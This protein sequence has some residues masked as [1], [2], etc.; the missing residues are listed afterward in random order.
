M[1]KITGRNIFFLI[2]FLSLFV[3]SFNSHAFDAGGVEIE[4]EPYFKGGSIGWDQNEG[5]GGHKFTIGGGLNTSIRYDAFKGVVSFD[6]WVHGEKMD[7]DVGIIPEDGYTISGEAAYRIAVIDD[8]ALSPYTIFGYEKWNR[9]G[10][11]GWETLEFYMLAV[12]MEAEFNKGYAKLAV[13][14][15]LSPA[16]DIQIKSEEIKTKPGLIAE[17]GMNFD[18]FVVGLFYKHL[19]FE[20]PDA[21][22]IQSGL[23]VGYRFK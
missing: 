22:I 8:I 7:D 17:V 19:G 16:V 18:S 2:L 15:P 11:F 6:K 4:L 12:G 13:L 9:D 20:D 5:I 21:K 14:T 10:M 1:K 3:F 23:L